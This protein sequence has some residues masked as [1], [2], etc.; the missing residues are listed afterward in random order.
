MASKTMV[1][2][3]LKQKREWIMIAQKYPDFNDPVLI[4]LMNR[5]VILS[6]DE[7]EYY[8]L[9]D[10]KIATWD[11]SKWSICYPFP[12]YDYSP[13]TDHTE[14]R[15]DV[16]VTHWSKATVKELI[17]WASR[18]CVYNNF[19]HLRMEVDK[20]HEKGVYRALIHAASVFDSIASADE[21]EEE[22]KTLYRACSQVMNDLQCC[23]DQGGLLDGTQMTTGS[24]LQDY[25]KNTKELKHFLIS[26]KMPDRKVNTTDESE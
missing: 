24:K 15:A 11:G 8:P 13:L 19:T 26:G 14:L 21:V 5:S 3:I 17:G 1:S 6:E 20:E 2:N 12:L 9:E 16:E 22:T 4:R 10:M 25:F 7:K 23:M 18:L